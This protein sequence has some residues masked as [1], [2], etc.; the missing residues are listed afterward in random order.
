MLRFQNILY[1]ATRGISDG[2]VFERALRLAES[3]QARLSVVDL[4]PDEDL[5]RSRVPRGISPGDVRAALAEAS[6]EAL[7]AYIESAGK[8]VE[9]HTETLYGVDFIEAI[10]AV[11]QRRHDLVVKAS[12]PGPAGSSRSLSSLDMHLLRKCPVPVWLMKPA[13]DT[14]YRRVLA[15]VDID[16]EHP[17]RQGDSLNRRIL[18]AAAGQA[19]ADGAELHVAHAWQPAYAGIL[20]TR[21]VFRHKEDERSYIDSERGLHRQALDRLIE[22]SREWLGAEAFD[23]LQ[24]RVHLRQGLAGATI[25]A[26]TAELGADLLVMGTV[27]RTGMA[28]LIIGNTAETILDAI[29]CSILAVKPPGF[30][31]PVAA[32]D[33]GRATQSQ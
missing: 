6:A 13:M 29:D 32:D 31:S 21:G 28:G 22:H 26:L 20:R 4:R 33:R 24:P 9:L 17:V 8:R 25:P 10:R 18:E 3:H 1:V 11:L 19:L 23:Y 2:A 12:Q 15:A 7:Q 5:P 27:A 30:R 14:P 16:M